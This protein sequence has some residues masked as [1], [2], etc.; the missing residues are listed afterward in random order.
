MKHPLEVWLE[1]LSTCDAESQNRFQNRFQVHIDIRF[2]VGEHGDGDPFDGTGGTLAHAFFPVYGG[3]AHFD[4]AESWTM[5]SYTGQLA[6][7]WFK[8][9]KVKVKY[10]LTSV[11]RITTMTS[12]K[13][14]H[15]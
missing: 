5:N 9:R 6:L 11:A 14:A 7:I 4:D 3:D 12:A 10:L 1:W 15:F 2:E 8:T 13:L